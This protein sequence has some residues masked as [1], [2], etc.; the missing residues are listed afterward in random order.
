MLTT[1]NTQT[2]KIVQITDELF[3]A[4]QTKNYQLAIQV[5]FAG[6]AAAVWDDVYNKIIAVEHFTFQGV[7]HPQTLI[8]FFS[9]TM[10]Q[11]LLL[12]FPYKKAIVAYESNKSTLVP[13]ALFDAAKKEQLFT[14]N[15]TKESSDV[16][17]FDS[18]NNIE[19]KNIYSI[20]AE[21]ERFFIAT[22]ANLQLKHA[23]SAM[24]QHAIIANKNS[25]DA[26]AIV[27]VRINAFD[28]IVVKEGKLLFFNSF[29]YQEPEDFIYFLIF[30]FE[31]IKLNTDK[32]TLELMGEIEK[33]TPLY[34][35]IYKYIRNVQ[36]ASKPD[37]F[38]YSTKLSVL[39]KSKHID[40][41]SQFLY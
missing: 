14:F 35:V 39:G 22:Y 26:K 18:V 4:R 19:S 17:F 29:D 15:H 3:D 7:H 21:I 38:T 24:I 27:N 13:D 2:K 33:D 6:Y 9:A 8:N 31:Q 16:V 30:A 12:G 36:F 34:A 23:A 10:Q 20:P 41:I 37:T 1:I 40:L 28:L 32:M 25:T 5:G 11:S